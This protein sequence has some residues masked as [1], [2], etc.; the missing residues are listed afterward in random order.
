MR[1]LEGLQWHAWL[2]QSSWWAALVGES[3]MMWSPFHFVLGVTEE[4]KRKPF[5]PP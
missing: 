4:G 3:S 1:P 5:F 2:P